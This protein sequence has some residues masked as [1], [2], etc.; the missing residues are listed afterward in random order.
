MAV[1]LV[2]VDSGTK[3][4][5]LFTPGSFLSHTHC[6]GHLPSL[7]ANHQ[8]RPRLKSHRSHPSTAPH[9]SSSTPLHVPPPLTLIT[10][11]SLLVHDAGAYI[12]AGHAFWLNSFLWLASL[13]IHFPSRCS[14]ALRYLSLSIQ[15][16][17]YGHPRSG[18]DAAC[19]TQEDGDDST[20][21]TTTYLYAHPLPPSSSLSRTLS[22]FLVGTAAVARSHTS[23]T[24]S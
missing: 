7:S 4:R 10:A 2:R 11:S 22:Y 15:S 24:G 19:L 18:I 6:L 21:M 16:V 9:I 1:L 5:L 17:E 12:Q 20:I 8:T 23:R 14:E 13:S 3:F